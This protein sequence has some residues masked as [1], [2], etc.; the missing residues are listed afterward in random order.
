MRE[1]EIGTGARELMKFYNGVE[2]GRKSGRELRQTTMMGYF[3]AGGRG[4]DT[5][6]GVVARGTGAKTRKGKK[7]NW[8]KKSCLNECK[9]GYVLIRNR[10]INR[11]KFLILN[12]RF[13]L[14]RNNI[15]S[16]LVFDFSILFT[17]QII[18]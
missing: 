8:V 6:L 16:Y 14:Y 13:I 10:N 4:K 17:F 18:F 1:R 11:L 15:I 2:S 5:P 9:G 3:G 12:A 7:E